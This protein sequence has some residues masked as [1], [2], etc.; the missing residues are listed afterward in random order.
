M[1]TLS[2]DL[3]GETDAV[4]VSIVADDGAEARV[5]LSVDAAA[6]FAAAML[7][8]TSAWRFGDD[9]AFIP[10]PSIN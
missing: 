4:A 9:F 10:T 8:A 1:K 3:S 5:I 7:D 6:D 2:F